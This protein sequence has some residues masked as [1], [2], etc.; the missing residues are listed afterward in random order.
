M[1]SCL[2]IGGASDAG[3]T[4]Q[5]RR[6]ALVHTLALLECDRR[7]AAEHERIA[8]ASP[9]YRGFMDM[10]L[11]ERWVETTPERLLA[12]TLQT[13]ADRFPLILEDARRLA[14]RGRPVLVEGWDLLPD[15]VAPH[16]DDPR[17]AIWL[18]PS[19][20]FKRRSWER[21]A[22]PSWRDQVSDPERAVANAFGRDLLLGEEIARQAKANGFDTLLVDGSR[23][24][25]AL[26]ALL[27]ER[28][29]PFL[30]SD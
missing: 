11:E 10:S 13:F 17:R 6:L 25:A 19:E 12:H 1:T 27:D 2:W 20:A 9:S 26:A 29:R 4:T 23:S 24:E 8:A 14:R 30:D 5:A 21:R 28:F 7:D 18:L 3:K 15:L 22:K 16:I